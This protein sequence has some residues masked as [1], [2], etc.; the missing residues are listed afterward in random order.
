[1]GTQRIDKD[2]GTDHREDTGMRNETD[3]VSDKKP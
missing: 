3:K 1:L 2:G